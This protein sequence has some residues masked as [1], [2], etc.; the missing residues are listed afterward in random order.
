M[1]GSPR[2]AIRN[3]FNEAVRCD[4]ELI[5]QRMRLLFAGVLGPLVVLSVSILVFG[6]LRTLN[7]LLFGINDQTHIWKG[8]HHCADRV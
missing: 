1:V 5:L 4:C 8:I 7:T 3:M 6:M 2:Y